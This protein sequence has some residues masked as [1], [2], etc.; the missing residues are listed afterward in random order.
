MK[1]VIMAKEA[2]KIVRDYPNITL[3]QAIYLVKH[4][5]KEE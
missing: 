4:I 2:E 3:E 5:Y 1:A